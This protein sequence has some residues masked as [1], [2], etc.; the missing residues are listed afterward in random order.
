MTVVID[1][2]MMIVEILPIK[3]EFLN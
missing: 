3:S 2:F 1:K